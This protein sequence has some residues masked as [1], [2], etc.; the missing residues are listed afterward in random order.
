LSIPLT[1]LK[2]C[3]LSSCQKLKTHRFIGESLA[4]NRPEKIISKI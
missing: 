3:L 1:A 2:T 4:T